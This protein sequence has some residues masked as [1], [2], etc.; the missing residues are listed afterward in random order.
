M[1]LTDRLLVAFV[2]MLYCYRS[3]IQTFFRTYDINPLSEL[4]T[5]LMKREFDE[6]SLRLNQTFKTFC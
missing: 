3:V 2:Q 5:H 1:C 4:S 6:A